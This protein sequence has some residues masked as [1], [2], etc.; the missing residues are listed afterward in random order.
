MNAVTPDHDH[1]LD[2]VDDPD[3][4]FVCAAPPPGLPARYHRGWRDYAIWCAAVQRRVLPTA[5]LTMLE[6]LAE[7]PGATATLAGRITAVNAAHRAA[8]HAVPGR[9]E[10]LRQA[11]DDDRARRA[12]RIRAVVEAIV[13]RIPRWGWPAG[14]AGRRNAALLTLAGTGL[15]RAA[16]AALTLGDVVTTTDADGRVLVHLGGAPLATLTAADDPDRCP[17]TALRGW[18]EV[19]GALQRYSGH[20]L[21]AHA[22]EN[23]TL[24]PIPVESVDPGQPLFVLLDRHGYA[25]TPHTDTPRRAADPARPR[26]R[27]D[28]RGHHPPPVRAAG[29]LPDPVAHTG[30][31][32][33][34]TDPG[35][36]ADRRDR[37]RRRLLRA[38][39]RRPP[40]RRR[41]PR[42]R[43]RPPRRR[44]GPDGRLAH[45]HRRAHRRHPRHPHDV[46]AHW[47]AESGWP[48]PDSLT[49]VGAGSHAPG[50][51]RAEN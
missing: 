45:P 21:L 2:D 25:P 48:Q 3:G 40:P 12:A 23:H 30:F 37:A 31:R 49:A 43:R 42:R 20:A 19:R 41:T 32:R 46:N 24:P 33:S 5:P 22:L 1:D 14:L 13:P 4:E 39:H 44:A 47:A 9:A 6:F 10:A 38:R 11:L 18:L 35:A 50:M 28:Q 51:P 16:I 17:V 34:G 27:L 36:G 7:H 29:A 15:P 8:G 26:R